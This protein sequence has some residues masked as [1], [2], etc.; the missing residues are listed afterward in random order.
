MS[1]T[2]ATGGYLVPTGTPP[3]EDD[4]LA[5]A[6]QAA[7]VGITGLDG[8]L[9]RPRWQATPPQQ[10]SAATSWA[11]VGVVLATPDANAYI[12][13]DPTGDGADKMQRHETLEVLV[14][15][16]GPQASAN[17]ARLR[18]GLALAQNR[19]MIRTATTTAGV[20]IGLSFIACGTVIAVPDLVNQR[21]LRRC[22]LPLTFRRRI[23]RTYPVLNLLSAQG[24]FEAE[25]DHSQSWETPT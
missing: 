24:S 20:D 19:D 22:D 21:W 12:A 2:S 7:V 9:V 3:G 11:A 5:D 18:D 1:N 16:Y 8:T 10:P 23:D 14:S 4:S 6:L 15:F 25:P 13:H 17:A